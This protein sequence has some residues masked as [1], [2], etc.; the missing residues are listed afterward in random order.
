MIFKY[1]S[2]NKLKH[3]LQKGSFVTKQKK[4]PII[5]YAVE[6]NIPTKIIQHQFYHISKNINNNYKIALKLSLFNFDIDIIKNVIE[7]FVKK[8]IKILIDAENENLNNI[9]NETCNQLMWNYNKNKV[10]ILKTY[11]M[12]RKDSLDLLTYDSTCSINNNYYHG[13]KLVRGAYHNEDK[14]KKKNNDYVLYQNKEDTDM[15][16]NKGI[17]HIYN[18]PTNKYSIIASHNNESINLCHLLN[19]ENKIFE[20]AHLLGMNEK[21]YTKLV[22]E[23]ENVHVYI[24]YGPY[25]YMIPYLTRRLYENIDT[26]KYM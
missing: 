3:A 9:Y 10:N 2:G 17:L 14:N 16:F 6:N 21:K 23:K 24:P 22:K 1:I 5:N 15:N 19:K 8:D 18:N 12:Y 7:L 11:Q 25:K 13:I 4:I 26:I 20:Y